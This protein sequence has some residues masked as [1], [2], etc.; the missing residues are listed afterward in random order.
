MPVWMRT[1]AFERASWPVWLGTA[2]E[3]G[4]AG[5]YRAAIGRAPRFLGA[6]VRMARVYGRIHEGA[7]RGQ[8]DRFAAGDWNLRGGWRGRRARGEGSGEEHHT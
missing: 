4:H 8:I 7:T 5:A 6:R 1:A 3:T 2:P